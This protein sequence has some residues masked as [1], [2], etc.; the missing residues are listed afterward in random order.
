[1][2]QGLSGVDQLN[3]NNNKK[4][5]SKRE[6]RLKNKLENRLEN[7]E[8]RLENRLKTMLEKKI[9]DI[10]EIAPFYTEMTNNDD[11]DIY[12]IL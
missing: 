1:M 3:S 2:T 12:Q 7:R 9:N 4:Q 10:N 11:D 6:N 8:N 5:E